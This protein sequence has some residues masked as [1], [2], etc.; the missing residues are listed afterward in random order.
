MS[1]EVSNNRGSV[2]QLTPAQLADYRDTF[3]QVQKGVHSIPPLYQNTSIESHHLRGLKIEFLPKYADK[4]G[5]KL[6]NHIGAAQDVLIENLKNKINTSLD[7]QVLEV[8]SE[9]MK[10]RKNYYVNAV[11]AWRL[12]REGIVSVAYSFVTDL[13]TLKKKGKRNSFETWKLIECL[14]QSI[15]EERQLVAGCHYEYP[16]EE[17]DISHVRSD[18]IVERRSHRSRSQR[19]QRKRDRAF[20]DTGLQN[21]APDDAGLNRYDN[22]RSKSRERGRSRR[23]SGRY[24]RSQS[25]VD[26]HERRSAKQYQRFASHSLERLDEDLQIEG[27][28]RETGRAEIGGTHFDDPVDRALKYQPGS[29]SVYDSDENQSYRFSWFSRM[30]C[31]PLSW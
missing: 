27:A 18:P 23:E 5:K 26:P 31:N 29:V 4:F 11:F 7:Q 22:E 16:K 13:L 10:D 8:Q 30:S 14:P 17:M 28:C 20:S 19:V 2:L 15:I 12:E 25:Y 21:N 6:S 9:Y 1:T 3:M 24:R